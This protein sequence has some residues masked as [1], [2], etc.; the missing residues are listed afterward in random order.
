MILRFFSKNLA[1]IRM[2]AGRN[3]FTL[4]PILLLLTICFSLNLL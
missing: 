2:L 4:K 3:D 1:K